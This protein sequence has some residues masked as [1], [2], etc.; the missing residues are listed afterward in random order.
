MWMQEWNFIA[1][2]GEKNFWSTDATDI[3][4]FSVYLKDISLL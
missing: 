3:I 2:D 4:D 1:N